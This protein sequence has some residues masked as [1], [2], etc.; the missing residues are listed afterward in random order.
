VAKRRSFPESLAAFWRWLA[1][2]F[3][4]RDL[5]EGALVGGA[6]LLYFA[7]R[8]A[9]V[10][11]PETAYANA[12]DVLELQRTL[13]F[14]WEPD[15]QDWI[16]DKLFLVQSANIVYF[17]LHFPLIIVFGIW[18]YFA[19]RRKYTVMR[20][21]LLVSG[22][23]ALIVYWL[24]PVAP[25]RELPNLAL[26]VPGDPNFRCLDPDAPSYVISFIDTMK[27]HLGYAYQ[28]QSTAA[29]V[30]PYAAMPSLHFGW[31]MLLGGGIIWTFWQT[32]LRWLAVPI[33]VALPAMQ[34]ASITVTA[35]HFFLDAM[36][37]GAVCLTAIP[38]AWGLQRWGYPFLGRT[39]AR[40]PWPF[41]AKLLA[42]Q[43]GDGATESRQ[44][45]ARI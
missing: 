29:F 2:P 41:V 16:K 26:C 18:L 43:A 32:R 9:V 28:S 30:N 25:P 44:E 5:L 11:R 17:Y 36:A 8:G 33:G 14:F 39:L 19:N 15:M 31:D 20:D 24:Y 4:R 1:R 37:G 21:L 45:K 3:S 27:V 23:I 35:N 13:G 42:L 40:L 22:G 6:F 12:L 38:V 7:V 10:D 34:V